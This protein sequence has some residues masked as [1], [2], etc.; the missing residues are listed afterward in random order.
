MA[1]PT[2]FICSDTTYKARLRPPIDQLRAMTIV[3]VMKK[4][5]E[6]KGVVLTAEGQKLIDGSLD[7]AAPD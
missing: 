2:D 6:L 1:T 7:I 5:M 3:I 4:G